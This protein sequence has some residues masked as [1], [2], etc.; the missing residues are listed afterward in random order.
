MSTRL[1]LVVVFVVALGSPVSADD[2]GT[3]HLATSCAAETQRSFDHAVAVLHSFWYAHAAEEFTAITQTDPR[4]AMGF[5]GL[6]MSQWYP[7]WFPPTPAAL[8]AGAA[9]VERAKAIAKSDR[10][11]AWVD[12][13][14]VFYADAST[15]D[16]RS[17]ALRY[18]AAMRRVHER[19]PDDSE[20]AVFYA[21]ALDA[22]APPT[23][24]TYANQRKA[25]EILEPIFAAQPNHPGVAHYLIHSYDYPSLAD[26][27]LPAARRY[28]EIAPAAP[29]ALHMPSHIFTRLG[30]W[31]ESIDSNRAAAAAAR[32][33]GFLAE[34]LHSFDYITYAS[35]QMAKDA[36]AREI[37][38]QAAAIAPRDGSLAEAYALAA[39]PARFAVERNRWDEARALAGRSSPYAQSAALTAFARALGFARTGDPE[40]A[41]REVKA[42]EGLRDQLAA[43]GDRYWSGQVEIQRD[44]AAAWAAYAA[45]DEAQAIRLM[46]AAADLEDSTDKH[47]VTPSQLLPAR[48]LLGDLLLAV[49]RWGEAMVEFE[50]SLQSAPNRFRS[51]AGAAQA[52][53]R[54]G[55]AAR[56]RAYRERLVALCPEGDTER[57]D[58]TEARAALARR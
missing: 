40:A 56:A 29:H 46:R 11:A 20:A 21:L 58:L 15:V 3:V 57:A 53:E 7:L 45:G 18:E 42:L 35:L 12:A 26:R 13:I 34:Q 38:R 43:T 51:Y 10:E 4:C 55:D 36:E 33:D 14:A 30:L 39:I 16:H 31:R 50:R 54:A 32:A 19:Y 44:A 1:A 52:A 47:P 28:G 48:E 9:A 22:T 5:W 49:G 23:D 6:A 25:A 8:R 24:K 2:V 27:G 41:G 17:R 37:V